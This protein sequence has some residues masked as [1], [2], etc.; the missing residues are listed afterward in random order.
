[1]LYG[2]FLNSSETP[3]PTFQLIVYVVFGVIMAIRWDS[4]QK[5]MPAGMLFV[6]SIVAVTVNVFQYYAFLPWIKDVANNSK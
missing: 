4:T 3:K 5:L 2:A 1:M 6:L